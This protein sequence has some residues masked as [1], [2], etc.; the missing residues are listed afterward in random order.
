MSSD[1]IKLKSIDGKEF[2]VRKEVIFM[3]EYIKELVKDEEGEVVVP[4]VNIRGDILSKVID[5]CEHHYNNPMPEIEK[6][7]KSVNMKENTDEWDANFIEVDDDT[8]SKIVIASNLLIIRSLLDLACAKY[9]SLIKDKKPE[10]IRA[11]FNIPNDF[12]PEEESRV[13]EENKWA[14]EM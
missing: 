12:T 11:R 1:N 6:P 13:R 2:T 10:E 3:S 9:A 5:F 7:L 14:E 4:A 8:L